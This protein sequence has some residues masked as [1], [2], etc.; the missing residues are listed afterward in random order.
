MKEYTKNTA[1]SY[2]DLVGYVA[3]DNLPVDLGDFIGE[4]SEYKPNVIPKKYNPDF[5]E[6]WQ[7]LY[8]NFKDFEQY[9]D[10]MGKI[11]QVPLPRL[12]SLIFS[13]E[14]TKNLENFFDD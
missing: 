1:E 7:T 5:P 10:F 12:K 6:D 8:V 9:A 13:R 4:V 3:E 11:G 2:D 14:E